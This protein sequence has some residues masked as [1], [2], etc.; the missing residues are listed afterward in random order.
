MKKKRKLLALM[1]SILVAGSTVIPLP[2]TAAQIKEMETSGKVKHAVSLRAAGNMIPSYQYG[3]EKELVLRITNHT[4]EKLENIVIVPQVR[5]DIDEWPFEIEQTSY[6]KTIENLEAGKT[7][8]VKYKLRAREEVASKYYSV[9]FDILYQEEEIE[10]SVFVKMK[11]KPEQAPEPDPIPEQPAGDTGVYNEE[12][13]IISG[14]QEV[15]SVPRVIVTGFSTDPAEVKAGTNFKLIV[16]LKNTSRT[17]AV[18]NML[19]DFSAPT[20]GSDANTA[21]PAFLPASGSST[22]YLDGIAANGAKDISIDLNAKADLVQKPYSIELL[23]KYEDG[24]AVQ[25]ES[26]SS[27]SVPVK[28]DARFEFSEFELSSD[29]VEVGGEINV[30]CNLYNLGRVKLYNLKAR[31]EGKGIESRE[32]FVGNVEPGATAVI[33][34]MITGQK[35]TKED[36][37]MKMIVTYEDESG[38]VSTAEKELTIYVT[39]PM[40]E[41]EII[42][43]EIT[44]QP[45]RA[46]PVIPVV[47][48]IL[49]AAGIVIGAIVRKKKTKKRLQEEE[50]LLED[51]LDRFT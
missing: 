36:D 12:P 31:F 1:M 26:A 34:G 18:K 20:E 22:V 6:E 5:A 10:Q 43:E 47:I 16:H 2:A 15:T 21:S 49:I 46:F 29:M 44:D 41:E 45:A 51:E 28:Q 17:T 32:I 7:E 35:V 24:K 19:F 13:E 40:E 27:I 25:Y 8:E 4:K 23:M 50:E 11:A 30:M 9:K 14:E 39:T 3:Q 48:L 37:K 33:D 42:P 38:I